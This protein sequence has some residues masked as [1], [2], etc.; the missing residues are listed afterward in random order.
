MV[1]EIPFDFY[2]ECEHC[3]EGHCPHNTMYTNSYRCP[4]GCGDG[5]CIVCNGRGQKL[6]ELG[7]K[8]INF[9]HHFKHEIQ[10]MLK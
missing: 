2:T 6:T 5:P 3:C 10:G 8:F 4:K 9:L 1:T 7:E